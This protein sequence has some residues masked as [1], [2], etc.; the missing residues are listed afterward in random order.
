MAPLGAR[1]IGTI[2]AAADF[3]GPG[4]IEINRYQ[5]EILDLV[6]RR[7]VLGQR[8]N[9][10]PATGQPSRYFEQLAIPVAAFTDPRAISVTAT[11]PQRI[12]QVLTLKALGAQIN[13]SMFDVEVNQ[14][15]GQF[16]YLEAKDLTDTVDS[17]LKLHDTALW[18]GNDTSLILP[19]TTQY[20]GISG[21]VV[22]ATF[23]GTAPFS[24]FTQNVSVSATGSLIDTVKSQVA[25]MI[26]RTDFEVKPSALYANPL[27]LDLFDREAKTLQLYYNETEVIPG[28]IV[29]AIPTQAGLLPL[30]PDAAI[31]ILAS[32]GNNAQGQAN[33]Q[34][35]A[36][37]LSEEFIEYHWLTSP[38]PRVFQLGLLG[39]L[40]AQF[41]VIKFGAVVAKGASYAHSHM[42]TVR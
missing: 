18:T 19:T 28:V 3:L 29:K 32:P 24:G 8:I 4:A 23:V 31:P 21:Q 22:N 12:E 13:Y 27:F 11:Q 2:S 17:V 16:A 30:V 15:Q 10:T 7:F 25:G 26:S 6:R 41:V 42:Y 1:F 37:I 35:E 33:R 39:N 40:A 38:V 20:F 9:Q 36:F 34:F 5:A 14:Q